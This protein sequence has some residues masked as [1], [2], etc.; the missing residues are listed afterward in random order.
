MSIASSM[1]GTKGSGRRRLVPAPGFGQAVYD[2]MLAMKNSNGTSWS[3]ADLAREAGVS[4]TTVRQWIRGAIPE[5]R[6]LGRLAEV[7]QVDAQALLR[8]EIKPINLPQESTNHRREGSD[9]ARA[10]DSATAE[11]FPPTA[12]D[13]LEILELKMRLAV[14]ENRLVTRAEMLEWLRLAERAT[15]PDAAADGAA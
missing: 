1:A 3:V 2:R 12:Q 7:L 8:G 13:A 11:V 14:K 6:T 10:S 9:A 4:G 15:R 5:G